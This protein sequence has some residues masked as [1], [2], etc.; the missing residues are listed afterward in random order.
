[1]ELKLTLAKGV[2]KPTV[3]TLD[4]YYHYSQIFE[5]AQTIVELCS[6][7]GYLSIFLA[8]TLQNKSILAI[9]IY[10]AAFKS[11][12]KNIQKHQ[13]SITAL[14]CSVYDISGMHADVIVCNPPYIYSADCDKVSADQRRNIDGGA[15]G[16]N[17]VYHIIKH[18]TAQHIII[19]LGYLTQ[20]Q[21]LSK[22]SSYTLQSYKH[23]SLDVY[24]VCLSRKEKKLKK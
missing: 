22:L 9:E 1:M 17:F 2:Y 8:K 16:L 3:E 10:E 15:D 20:I 4:L 23:A 19:E 6:G 18:T 24:Y 13:V 12:L 14:Q 5:R 7:S 21:I 11:I